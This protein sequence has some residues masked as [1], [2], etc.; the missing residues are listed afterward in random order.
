MEPNDSA[1][2]APERPVVV[3]WR[4]SS[5][6]AC[7]ALHKVQSSL[8][9]PFAYFSDTVSSKQGCLQNAVKLDGQIP[10]CQVKGRRL[11]AST[12][13]LSHSPTS[14][15]ADV[16]RGI[17]RQYEEEQCGHVEILAISGGSGARAGVRRSSHLSRPR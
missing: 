9:F 2:P 5:G 11:R 3:A 6:L 16:F 12:S 7:S 4:D 8:F 14:L 13:L 15:V 10:E 1:S 17:P